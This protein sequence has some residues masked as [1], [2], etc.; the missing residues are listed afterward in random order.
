M[1][2]KNT[3][4]K[5]QDVISVIAAIISIISDVLEILS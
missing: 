2:E 1:D 3:K 5:T 4:F